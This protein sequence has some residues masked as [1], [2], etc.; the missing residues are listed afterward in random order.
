MLLYILI[1]LTIISFIILFLY[2]LLFK[3]D[4]TQS[5]EMRVN[6]IF[7][8]IF[9]YWSDDS[10][11]DDFKKTDELSKASVQEM[12]TSEIRKKEIEA[13]KA[14]ENQTPLELP[15]EPEVYNVGQNIFTYKEAQEVCKTLDGRLANIDD[16]NEAYELGANWCNN[17][18]LSGKNSG[19]PIQVQYNRKQIR[20]GEE[21]CGRPG[22]NSAYLPFPDLKLSANCYGVRPEANEKRIKYKD[23][24]NNKIEVDL[25]SKI[26]KEDINV[27]PFNQNRWSEYSTRESTY[28]PKSFNSDNYLSYDLEIDGKDTN[29][30]LP[31]INNQS[32]EKYNKIIKKETRR[33]NQRGRV[34]DGK[35]RGRRLPDN[36]LSANPMNWDWGGGNYSSGA[37]R[38][39]DY[40]GDEVYG[41]EKRGGGGHANHRGGGHA[42]HR[43]GGGSMSGGGGSMSGGGGSMSGG[44][45]SMSG[46]G[47]SMSGGGGSMSGGGGSMSGAGVNPNPSDTQPHDIVDHLDNVLKL[48]RNFGKKWADKNNMSSEFNS[49][50]DKLGLSGGASGVASGVASGGASGIMPANFSYNGFAQVNTP[51]LSSTF[52]NDNPMSNSFKGVSN[53]RNDTDNYKGDRVYKDFKPIQNKQPLTQVTYDEFC[54][55][56]RE[57]TDR[58]LAFSPEHKHKCCGGDQPWMK[59][60]CNANRCKDSDLCIL[61]TGGSNQQKETKQKHKQ[62]NKHNK[63]HDSQQPDSCTT[64]CNKEKDNKW[65]SDYP[66]CSTRNR[67]DDKDSCLESC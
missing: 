65:C 14:K 23:N 37:V 61:G 10:P 34:L 63:Q 20:D 47:G 13:I 25:I 33:F 62:H 53:A 59:K 51:N 32:E 21:V 8:I 42:N 35:W 57:C 18:W 44:G 5:F 27:L 11:K 46:G 4:K 30:N 52:D 60:T 58:C 49:F 55:L 29:L 28:A 48:G 1:L 7:G 38:R 3:T 24:I 67:Y 64:N 6:S 43:G 17:G 56:G 66:T 36:Y 39:G 54:G 16:M 22:I 50:L 15:K 12:I 45:G 19:Y 31:D 2:L 40:T 9:G 26:N 41:G